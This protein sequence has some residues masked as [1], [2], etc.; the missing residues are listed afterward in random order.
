MESN[1][2]PQ[3]PPS[4]R[5]KNSQG[6]SDQ[7]S[8]GTIVYAADATSPT[9]AAEYRIAI[10]ELLGFN[11]EESTEHNESN[12]QHN[13][14]FKHRHLIGIAIALRQIRATNTDTP[15]ED[16]PNWQQL[17]ATD[18]RKHIRDQIPALK[19]EQCDTHFSARAVEAIYEFLQSEIN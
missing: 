3:N 16:Y 17:T 4:E 8:F 14:S 10:G 2:S 1:N 11:F 6:T 12:P 13:T 18:I 7:D 19:M 9:R 5:L 15:I